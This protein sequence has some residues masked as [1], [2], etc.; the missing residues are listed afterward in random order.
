MH[1]DTRSGAAFQ[2]AEMQEVAR[3]ANRIAANVASVILGKEEVIQA[4]IVALLAGGHIIIEDYPGVGKTLLA[5]SLIH[6]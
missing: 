1:I 2:D 4:C 5:L 6:I 3:R